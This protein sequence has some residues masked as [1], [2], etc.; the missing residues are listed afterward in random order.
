M[1]FPAPVENM[2]MPKLGQRRAIHFRKLD[3][4]Q[5]FL[6]ADRTEGQH[7][8]N[9]LGVCRGQQARM[10]GDVFGGYVAGENDRGARRRH[11]DL[12]VREKA[13]HFFRSR[14]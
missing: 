6:R 14:A 5:N 13:M 11:A 3:F 7:V 12:L 9:I 10:F 1:V 8:D 4:Q 2:L